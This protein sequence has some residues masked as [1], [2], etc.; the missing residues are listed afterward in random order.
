MLRKLL[1][2]IILLQPVTLYAISCPTSDKYLEI[3]DTKEHVLE[4][5]GKP[6]STQKVDNDVLVDGTLIYSKPSLH[7]VIFTIQNQYVIKIEEPMPCDE[8]PCSEVTY[9][10]L[11]YYPYCDLFIYV[12]HNVPFVIRN[13]G[14]PTKIKPV[15]MIPDTTERLVYPST[16]GPNVLVIYNGLLSDWE[17]E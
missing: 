5:C 3:G 15:N 16:V 10:T 14:V 17:T 12:G 11:D 6:T 4:V 13:C 2:L 7:N 1:P 9:R 8:Q